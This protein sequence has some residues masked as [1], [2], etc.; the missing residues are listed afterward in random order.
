MEMKP[1]LYKMSCEKWNILQLFEV[2]SLGGWWEDGTQVNREISLSGPDVRVLWGNSFR[3]VA[4]A[5]FSFFLWKLYQISN[6]FQAGRNV[7]AQYSLD[8]SILQANIKNVQVLLAW[9][10]QL[11]FGLLVPFLLNI[12]TYIPFSDL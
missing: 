9:K 1:T 10:S 3:N 5:S 2:H 11:Y 6:L 4:T 8:T 12:L 7:D